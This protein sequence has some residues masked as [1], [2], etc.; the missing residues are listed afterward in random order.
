VEHCFN[1]SGRADEEVR[2]LDFPDYYIVTTCG[3]LH[4]FVL[5][6]ILTIVTSC[7]LDYLNCVNVMSLT[8]TMFSAVTQEWDGPKLQV[9]QL[10]PHY[11]NFYNLLLYIHY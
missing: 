9:S 6:D 3:V 7:A 5:L 1:A 10:P 8:E 11:N 4:L 2:Y